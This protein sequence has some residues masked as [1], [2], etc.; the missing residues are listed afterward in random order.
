MILGLFFILSGILIVIF[1]P[2]LRVIV[3]LLLLVIGFFLMAMSYYYK[4]ISKRSVDNPYVD[5]FIRF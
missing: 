4:K 1:E 5:F 2:F 3:A